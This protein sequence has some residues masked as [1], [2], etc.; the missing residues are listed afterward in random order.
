MPSIWSAIRSGQAEP[1]RLTR[2]KV[3][4]ELTRTN[5][6]VLIS[7]L[8]AHLDGAGIDHVVLDA[9][10]SVLEGSI[11]AIQR[12]VMVLAED[13]AAARDVFEARPDLSGP[14]S[15]ETEDDT[16]VMP[17]VTSVAPSNG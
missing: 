13:E 9:H 17:G 2:G 5:D 3:L 1:A 10:T 14:T 8:V 15:T 16:T 12:R 11:G 7:W 4:I 6:P